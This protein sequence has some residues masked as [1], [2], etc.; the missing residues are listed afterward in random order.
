M[1]PPANLP[2]VVPAG[3][4]G[5]GVRVSVPVAAPAS[6]P[7]PAPAPAAPAAERAAAARALAALVARAAVLLRAL[8]VPVP[9]RHVELLQAGL[10]AQPVAAGALHHD[11]RGSGG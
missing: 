4:L 11:R 7:A 6:P 10:D 5:P 9:G 8:P 2:G 3:L 1:F